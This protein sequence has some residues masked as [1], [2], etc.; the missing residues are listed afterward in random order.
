ML[1]IS[2][3][4]VS[5]NRSHHLKQTLLKNIQDN[6]GYDALEFVVLNYNSKD[7]M[8]EWVKNEM[9]EHITSGRLVYYRTYEPEHFT[10]S[11]SKNVAFK[12]ASGDIVCN[13]NADNYAGYK[14]ADYVNFSFTNRSDIVLTPV[15]PYHPAI[16]DFASSE[17]MGKVCVLKQHFFRV[18]G[19]DERIVKYG[20]EDIDFINRLEFAN[21]SRQ[22]LTE[23]S[24][25]QYIT[26]SD[27]ERVDA[28]DIIGKIKSVYVRFDEP[29]VSHLVILNT[30][31]SF[32]MGLLIDNGSLDAH[33]YKYA[34]TQRNFRFAFT[35]DNNW[36]RG[37]WSDSHENLIYF[38]PDHNAEPFS[39][40]QHNTQGNSFLTDVSDSM[41]Y[42]LIDSSALKQISGFMYLMNS[43]DIMEENMKA[44][45][46]KVNG[47]GFGKAT[48]FK[49]FDYD[50]PIYI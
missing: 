47:N 6:T 8:E 36:I 33:L 20:Y 3:C 45:R 38:F 50:T 31:A 1:K 32:D 16:E 49:N 40:T 19:F 29:G 14:F 4:I 41:F 10:Q 28:I 24:F 2:F 11:H 17:V 7:D 37:K 44:I 25:L 26:H 9:S 42:Q 18:N 23:R 21:I 30:D 46:I 43:R 5:M 12:L 27:E 13:I 15:V 34:Y 35:R 39:L 22:L 48:V